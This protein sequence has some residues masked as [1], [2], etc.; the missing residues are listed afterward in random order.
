MGWTTTATTTSCGG[1]DSG[2]C[3]EDSFEFAF[4]STVHHG[5][6]FEDDDLNGDDE[7]STTNDGL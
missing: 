5:A 2:F 6:R 3:L 1:E 7:V 4:V